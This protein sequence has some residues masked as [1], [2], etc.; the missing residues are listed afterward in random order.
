MCQEIS[1]P[2][3]EILMSYDWPDNA[4]AL[5]ASRGDRAAAAGSFTVTACRVAANG[6]S[7]WCGRARLVLRRR[8]AI[9]NDRI[10]RLLDDAVHK[11]GT[12]A[13]RF[14]S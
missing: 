4:G 13:R 5:K 3:I 1:A 8:G 11:Y 10:Q 2:A 12:G 7:V 14:R 6:E 9:E